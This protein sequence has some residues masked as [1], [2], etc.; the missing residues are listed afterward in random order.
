MMRRTTVIL[1]L[2][3]AVSAGRALAQE[4]APA[5]PPAFTSE[6]IADFVI[7]EANQGVGV[8]D[9]HFYAIDNHTIGK[10]DKAGQQVDLWEG[11]EDGPIKHLDSAVIVDGKLYASHSNYPEWPMTSSIEIFDAATL[12]HI[13]THSFGIERG[14]FTWLDFHDGAWWGGFANYNRVFE[15]S[16]FAYGNKYNTQ[17]VR[18]D[19][20]WRVAEAGSSP[21]RYS[22]NSRT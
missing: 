18:F 9:R 12:D 5:E 1:A 21:T 10:Y 6:P 2:F 7:P 20:Q 16:P 13:D 22:R 3:C 15:R 19:D 11:G 14:S 17:V 4:E 8:D